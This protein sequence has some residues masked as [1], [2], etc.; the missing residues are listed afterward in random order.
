MIDPQMTGPATPGRAEDA[1]GRWRSWV[2]VNRWYLALLIPALALALA[3]SLFRTLDIALPWTAHH[4]IRGETSATLG[5]GESSIVYPDDMDAGAF[6][7][8]YTLV[9]VVPVDGFQSALGEQIAAMPGARLWKVTLDASAP[10]DMVLSECVIELI[11]PD[12]ARYAGAGGKMADGRPTVDWW[13]GKCT[14]ADTPGPSGDF[15]DENWQAPDVPRPRNFRIDVV[16]AVPTT[17]I[18]TEVRLGIGQGGAE[19]GTYWTIP[20][21]L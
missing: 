12:G 11:G 4:E 16:I 15:P 20:T 17:V 1:G 8:T 7:A 2:R 9:G 10:P 19:R 13:S 5:T 18:P 21:G 6:Q 14:P 3:A